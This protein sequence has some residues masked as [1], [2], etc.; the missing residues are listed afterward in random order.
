MNLACVTWLLHLPCFS[1]VNSITLSS[2]S[3]YPAL[4][5]QGSTCLESGCYLLNYAGCGQCHQ[6]GLLEESERVREEEDEEETITFK[7]EEPVPLEI[8]CYSISYFGEGA[9]VL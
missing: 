1:Y 3:H 4:V 6:L 9:Y 7:R 8:C 2:H 5:L